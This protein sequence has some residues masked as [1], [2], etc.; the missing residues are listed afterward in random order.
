M[1]A[2][3]F[4][5]YRWISRIL[6][7][8]KLS[9]RKCLFLLYELAIYLLLPF[10]LAYGV[11]NAYNLA[12]GGAILDFKEFMYPIISKRNYLD[13]IQSQLPDAS[14]AWTGATILFM[15]AV[16]PA[17]FEIFFPSREKKEFVP[18][19]FLLGV[20]NLGVM[21][22][23][24]NGAAEGC[25]FIVLFL[26]LILQGVFLQGCQD[27]YQQ[28][29]LEKKSVFEGA[30]QFLLL[31][32]RIITVFILFIMAFDSVYSMPGAWKKSSETIWKREEL[33]EF[34]QHIYYQIPPDAVAFGEGVPELMSMIDRDT[35]LHTT[36]WSYLNMPLDTMEEIRYELEKE[37]WFFCSL[38]SLHFLEQNFPGLTEGYVLHE[39]FE[40]NGD[41][42]AFFVKEE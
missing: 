1:V 8:E 22:Y 3:A 12:A 39:E 15:G 4:A 23:Y 35:H 18:F 19:V 21:L 40:Y 34:T 10:A 7:G 27:S 20:M 30:N 11:V 17:L 14:H 32:F 26:M 41:K 42:F 5:L 36:E 28:W 13:R 6:D 29:K 24:V 33:V 2:C 37:H 16:M 31:A 9:L 38:Y 25:L